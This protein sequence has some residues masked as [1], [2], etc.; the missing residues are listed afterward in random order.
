MSSAICA[1]NGGTNPMNARK[2][3]ML[4]RGDHLSHSLRKLKHHLKRWKCGGNRRG[5]DFKLSIVE[6]N[7]GDG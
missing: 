1:T 7:Q 6:T 2:P 4:P 3:S 5:V